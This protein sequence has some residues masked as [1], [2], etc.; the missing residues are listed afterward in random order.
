[1][2]ALRFLVHEAAT[3]D[4]HGS[5]DVGG[6]EEKVMMINDIARALFAA[7]ATRKIRV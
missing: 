5:S 6:S 7:H 4:D 2:E 3:L 1:M